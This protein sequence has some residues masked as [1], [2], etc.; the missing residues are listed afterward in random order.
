MIF[1]DEERTTAT[2]D[3]REDMTRGGY[4]SLRVK[5]QTP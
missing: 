3:L 1:D 2:V 4:E 5:E